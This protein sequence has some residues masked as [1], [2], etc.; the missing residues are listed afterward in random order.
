LKK[1]CLDVNVKRIETVDVN[2]NVNNALVYKVRFSVGSR[3]GKP[4][5]L[6][7]AVKDRIEQA[8]NS[9]NG[10]NNEGLIRLAQEHPAIFYGLVSK[11]VPVQATLALS[12]V[13]LDLGLAMQQSQANL[14][15]LQTLQPVT[16]ENVLG[17][18]DNPINEPPAKSLKTKDSTK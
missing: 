3:K 7:A 8:F 4:N 17:T 14:E 2:V 13:T 16:L 9:V 11:L 6:T 15:Q 12:V 10:K 5:R 1:L 18:D